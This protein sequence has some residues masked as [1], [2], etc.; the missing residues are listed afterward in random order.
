LTYQAA[1]SR[2]K[3]KKKRLHVLVTPWQTRCLPDL[4]IGST[5]LKSG[6]VKMLIHIILL[7]PVIFIIAIHLQKI[8]C[9]HG[10]VDSEREIAGQDIW[11][12]DGLQL[13]FGFDDIGKR[14]DKG[15]YFVLIF[16]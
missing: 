8:A 16:L 11:D 7:T 2:Q 12:V 1:R 4:P 15:V 13:I 9:G 14:V 10:E 6:V 5:R 3:N